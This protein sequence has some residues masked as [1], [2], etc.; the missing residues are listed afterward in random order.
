MF[1]L[2][3]QL[4]LIVGSSR[5]KTTAP[6]PQTD[7][8]TMD[9]ISSSF[10]VSFAYDSAVFR[11]AANATTD[12]GV[13]ASVKKSE[14]ATNQPINYAQLNPIISAVPSVLAASQLSVE[15]QRDKTP[16][17][18]LA[19]NPANKDI[20][21]NELAARLLPLP[22][23]DSFQV[24]KLTSSNDIIGD[25]TQML[26]TTYQ[27]TP[28]FEG[29]LSYAVTWHGVVDGRP[30]VIK[31][32][33]LVAS[34]EVPAEYARILDTF[35]FAGTPKVQGLQFF[36][37]QK[38]SAAS[39]LD[40]K[41][42]ADLV[43]PS[44]V[45]IYHIVCGDLVIGSNKYPTCDGGTGSGALVS[46]DGYIATNGHVVVITA[47][48]MFVREITSERS[49]FVRFLQ[50]VGY[51]DAQIA[52]IISN[53][54]AIASLIAEIYDLPD[55][56]IFLD[57]PREIT[58]VS[59]G[60]EPLTIKSADA[61]EEVLSTTDSDTIKVAKVLGADYNSKDLWVA[62]SGDPSGFSSSD[63]ALL[64]INI[65]DAPS[66]TINTTPV[67]QNEKIIVL[68]FPGDA[69]NSL[70]DNSSLD[71]SVTNGSISAIKDAAGGTGKL[72][73]SDA[74]ASQGNS[75]GPAITQTGEI[76]GLLT[77]R[78][79]GDNQ[80]NAAKSYIRDVADFTDLAKE[81]SATLGG[82]SKTM[83]SWRRGLELYSQNHFSAAKKEFQSVKQAY[84]S[85]RLVDDYIDNATQQIAAGN[86]VPLYSPVLIGAAVVAGVVTLGGAI[87]LVVRH[88][89]KH[90]AY[91]SGKMPTPHQPSAPAAPQPSVPAQQPVA[92]QPQVMSPVAQPSVAST[93]LSPQVP[94][95]TQ[96]RAPQ[97]AP[98]PLQPT[99]TVIQPQPYQAPV[100]L[101]AAPTQPID[102]IITPN[103][104]QPTGY[105]Q[106]LTPK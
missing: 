59:L 26:K 58:L 62:Q 65:T 3:F 15:V 83:D 20:S 61:I 97:P 40:T 43:S 87:M 90:Q 46:A 10:G 21:E 95:M 45:K 48:D 96:V 85:H 53:P 50:G 106:D 25:G 35:T 86:D 34:S 72:Y 13:G 37:G 63:V 60:D 54:Q 39:P 30:V 44:V 32:T 103:A 82:A 17:Q 49:I 31:L 92:I 29:G 11:A 74:D 7:Q 89:A 75:G 68:G 79:A 19:Q 104:Q 4:G 67:T 64:K 23:S 12:N 38:A 47:K 102:Q 76:F 22:Q 56:D 33:G 27:F 66:L 24:A 5:F 91:L 80:G 101:G 81:K 1:L 14:F 99:P 16:L 36:E 51:S 93:G 100:A 94:P 71:V 57:Q 69:E 70:V 84:G 8:L 105:S 52:Q 78:V 42:I 88:R 9:T 98:A 55:T 28:K 2:M 73:Q 18:D 41:Y 6:A 77:Y